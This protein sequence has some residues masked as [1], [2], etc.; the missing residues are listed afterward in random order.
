M[1]DV[2]Y[3]PK[4]RLE[5]E[6]DVL[7][8]QFQG[9]G[10][11]PLPL[12]IL[13]DDILEGH[14]GLTLELGDLHAK[15]GIP[16]IGGQRDLLGALWVDDRS[17]FIDHTL[18]PHERSWREGRYRFTVAHEIG[19]WQMHRHLLPSHVNQPSL[20]HDNRE[21]TIVCRTSAAKERI[22][23]QAD[24]FA[25]CLLMPRA[26]VLAAWEAHFGDTRTR[27]APLDDEAQVLAI[28][29]DLASPFAE[30]FAVSVEAM[31]IRLEQIHLL[32]RGAL[33]QRVFVAVS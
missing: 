9:A 14:L 3:L 15:L 4:D 33:A 25:A 27:V 23:W 26:Q 24:L 5:H 18:D 7:L 13:V 11:A 20:F 8:A 21:P 31:R 28:C 17:V 22:E 1:F 29:R 16:V 32:R 12:P 10:K 19:H 2:P 30:R 6:A